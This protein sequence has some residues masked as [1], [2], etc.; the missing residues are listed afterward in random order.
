MTA[1]PAR[2]TVEDRLGQIAD[3]LGEVVK[4][5]E[6]V[7]GY[8]KKTRRLTWFAIVTFTLDIILTVAFVF[9]LSSGQQSACHASNDARAGQV[10][11]WNT[12]VNQFSDPNPTAKQRAREERFLHFI[13]AN[14]RKL[15]CHSFYLP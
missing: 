5:L 1:E 3:Q 2:Q 12:I 6:N 10:I 4:G 13:D 7:T 8:G 11:I 9:A 14:F 15:N